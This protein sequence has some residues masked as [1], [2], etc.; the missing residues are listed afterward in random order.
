MKTTGKRSL[1]IFFIVAG[2]FFGIGSFLYSFATQGGRWAVQPFNGHISGSTAS[3]GAGKIFDRNGVVLV[4][5]KGGKRVYNSD[6]DTR[7][8]MLH[9]VGDT[10]GF[11]S[12]GVQY[13]YKS[14]LSGYNL[15][16][17]L[18][19]PT[20]KS[21]GSDIHLTLDSKLCRLAR[22]KLGSR[23]GAAALYN[24][25]T[26][27]LLCMVSTP[28]FDPDSPPKDIDTNPA[29]KGAY[30][31]KVI[32]STFTPGSIFKLVTSAAAIEN[33]PDLDSRTWNC[34]GSITING[35]RITDVAPYGRLTFRQALAHSS[36]VAFSQIAIEVGASKMMDEA[37]TMGFGRSFTLGSIHS[38]ASNYNVKSVSEDQLGWSGVGQY[39]DLVNPYHYLVLMG[40]IANGGQPLMPYMIKNITTPVGITSKV[41]TA[42]LGGSLIQ[43][44]T[45]AR[46]KD[47]MRYNV[48]HEYGDS[49]FP[50]LDVCAKTGTGEVG[51]G[52]GPNCW[53]A[54]FSSNE[55]TP[56]AFVVLVEN[57]SSGSVSSAGRIA[58]SLMKAA[59]GS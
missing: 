59:A 43:S 30:F 42:T 1:I 5:S 56:Y 2:F 7:C 31:N 37:S 28:D 12:T 18:F 45:A 47:Y 27:E 38:A 36:N 41:G 3:A 11:I 19:S 13:N 52:K 6:Y 44:S 40:A 26:G 48:S 15:V 34:N 4:E 17:G 50:G 35:N 33:I 20:G 22:E 51:H 55:N 8:A 29:Y 54:G 16:T 39:T 10:Q 14:E 24:Y 9:T 46:L 25:R 32:S 21:L 58:S 53:M 49:L 23:N 57:S